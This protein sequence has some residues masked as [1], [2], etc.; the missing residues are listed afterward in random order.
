[1]GFIDSHVHFH[2][3]DYDQDREAAIERARQAG[4]EGFVNIATDLPSTRA[5]LALANAQ[6]DFWATA[7][8]HPHDAKDAD[9]TVFRELEKLLQHERV[10]AI[11]E[12][13]LDFFRDHS[14]KDVQETVF[15]K[16]LGLHAK[17][18][19]PLIIHC[20]DAYE[21]LL[22]ILR[23]VLPPPYIGIMHCFSSD[24]ATMKR[25]LDAG[26]AISFA[27][28]LTYKKNDTL[29]EACQA[30]PLDRLILETDAPFLSPQTKRGK[31]NESAYMLE[32]AEVAATL[33]GV[34]LDALAQHTAANTR[35]VLKL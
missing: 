32:T 16:F 23:E 19:K 29:R 24:K 17:T 20:R 14:P 15:R 1:M 26:F 11:G 22:R 6:P 33:H 8:V 34:K 5:S 27:G 28:P 18:R 10:V 30:C 25:F 21:D 13:G 12:V 31:R 4:V 35:Q 9:E 2:F 7:G 3:P